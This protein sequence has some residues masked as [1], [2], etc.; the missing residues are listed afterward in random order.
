VSTL[1]QRVALVTGAGRGIGAAIA[2][3]LAAN[4]AHVVVNYV[5]RSDTADATVAAI[6]SAGGRAFA[7][8]ADLQDPRQLERLFATVM[9]RCGRLD[10]LVNNAGIAAT[11][12]LDQFDVDLIDRVLAVNVRAVLLATQR[13]VRMFGPE[14]G[15]VINLS[16][17]LVQQPVPA[18]ALYAAAKGAIDAL[19]RALAHE[20]GARRIRVNAVAP[21]PTEAGL[22]QIDEQTRAYLA[23][24]TPLGRLGQPADIA[25]VV[26]FLASDSAAWVTGQIIGVDGGIRI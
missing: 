10:I 2:R 17:A 1:A 21:G 24:R 15:S 12:M 7:E 9:E 26:A 3:E 20:L 6:Q 4:G 19:T 22:L 5:A 13:A 14:G 11:S 18:H 25:K 23:S 8:K 16:S